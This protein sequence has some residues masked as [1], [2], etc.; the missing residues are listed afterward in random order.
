MKFTWLGQAGLL[1]DI[2]GYTIMID[3]YLSDSVGK[4]NGRH[5]HMEIDESYLKLAPDA[6]VCT[7]NHLDHMDPETMEV[8][9][10]NGDYMQVL[11]PWEAYLELRKYG[12]KHNYIMFNPQTEVTL[13]DKIMVKAVK[14]EHSD[15][16]ATGI[17]IYAEDKVVYVTGDTLYNNKIFDDLPDNIDIIFLP[18]NG[19]GN[20]MNMCDAARFA[21]KTG[22]K[23]VVPIHWGMLD[24]LDPND[25]KCNNRLIP[26]L[27]KETTI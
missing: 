4:F 26:E 15:L 3:P 2:D 11:A 22:A 23:T 24:D 7:H 8:I 12:G 20:N 16:T 19:E 18:V 27:Y 1:F 14:A 9:L 25:F 21:K 6:V 5:T 10:K 13:N 17:L